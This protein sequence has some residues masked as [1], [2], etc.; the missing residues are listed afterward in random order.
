MKAYLKLKSAL[1]LQ[2]FKFTKLC[3]DKILDGFFCCRLEWLQLKKEY[4]NLQREAMNNL[5]KQLQAK[6]S[7]D[8]NQK[9]S[10]ENKQS[11]SLDATASTGK[12][13]IKTSKDPHE[14]KREVKNLSY[15]PGV[16]LRFHC[17]NHGTTKKELRVGIVVLSR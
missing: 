14:Q 7:P 8:T 5:K 13:D 17:Q 4:K 16:V 3:I 12:K 11:H 9:Q 10:Q 15:V 1:N 2:Y 6:S